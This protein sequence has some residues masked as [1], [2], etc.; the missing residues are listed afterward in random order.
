MPFRRETW[1]I[2][3]RFHVGPEGGKCRPFP[4]RCFNTTAGLKEGS[5]AGW[6]VASTKIESSECQ[7]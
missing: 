7:G 1:C 2:D 3:S 6:T 5:P 4:W